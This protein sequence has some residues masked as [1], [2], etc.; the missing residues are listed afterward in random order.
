MNNPHIKRRTL[1]KAASATGIVWASPVLESVTAHAAGCCESAQFS[2]SGAVEPPD[3]S[4]DDGSSLSCSGLN[5]CVPVT[6]TG[7]RGTCSYSP[8]SAYDPGGTWS[9]PIRTYT[10]PVG[11]TCRILSASARLLSSSPSGDCNARFPCAL[12]SSISIDMPDGKF[13]TFTPPAGTTL[14]KFRM[15]LCC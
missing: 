9:D 7:S 4:T 5:P 8:G 12:S 3:N 15:I 10:L 11:S 1:L 2:A 13:V 6:T 14:W